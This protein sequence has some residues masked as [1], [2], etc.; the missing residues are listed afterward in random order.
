M[1]E[2]KK[3][4]HTFHFPLSLG[5]GSGV[6]LYFQQALYHLRE[7]PVISWISVLGTALSICMIM[8]IVIT[9]Q[10]RVA[11]C[12]PEVNRSRSLYVPNMSYR[13]KGDTSGSS[14]NSSM[15]VQT[16]REC[17]KALTTAEAVTLASNPGK[18]RVSLPAGAKMTADMVQTDEAFW[19]VFRFRFL[20]GKPFTAADLSSGL[21]RAVIT[22]SVA[23][24]LFGRTDVSGQHIELNHVDFQVCGVVADVSMLATDA[25]AQVWIPYTA[26]DAE[27]NS[28]GYNL[29]GPMRAV[30]LACSRADFPAIR[31]ECERL[32][33]KYN[34]AQ[35]GVEV[36]YRGQPDTQFTHL[37]RSWS[38]EP[39]VQGVVLRYVAVMLIL[40]IVPAINLSSMT[41]SRMRKRM[42]EIGVRKAFGA[43]ANE[44]MRQV[45]L[46]NLLLTCL[47]GLLGLL[48]SYAATFVLNG[49]LFGNSTNAYLSGETSLTAGELLSPWIFLAAFGF[50]LLM[51]LLSAGIPAWRASRMNIVEAINGKAH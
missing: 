17:F 45:F 26:G 24:R 19:Q 30:I 5:E 13:A 49:F 50:C 14:A 37:Y 35:E 33:Q 38:Q 1:T 9:L 10:V 36:F 44:L 40:L 43:T 41:L 20:D 34:D 29:M 39:D 12:E 2:M 25:Y 8:V 21:P 16:G 22:A 28:W 3:N 42:A 18:V 6:R 31:E 23:R 4:S 47:A 7:N 32:R 51:N 11:D 15:S 27:A 46:E 48:L